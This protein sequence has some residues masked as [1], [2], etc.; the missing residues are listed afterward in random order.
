MLPIILY[1][2]LQHLFAGSVAYLLSR[3][4][5]RPAAAPSAG[6]VEFVNDV[7]GVAVRG[8]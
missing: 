8:G 3:P 1:N 7:H 5:A 6:P 4:A 2:L